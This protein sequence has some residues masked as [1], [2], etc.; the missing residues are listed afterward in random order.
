MIKSISLFHSTLLALVCMSSMH[1]PHVPPPLVFARIEQTRKDPTLIQVRKQ[2]PTLW[3]KAEMLR[4]KAVEAFD[5]NNSTMAD[6][7]GEYSIVTYQHA[8][9]LKHYVDI[10]TQHDQALQKHAILVERI[11]ANE[12]A[13]IETDRKADALERAIRLRRDKLFP[14]RSKVTEPGREQARW[15]SVRANV[16]RAQLLC[17]EADIIGSKLA[18]PGFQDAK[19]L[20]ND[21][22]TQLQNQTKEAPIDASMHAHSLC[23]KALTRARNFNPT[24]SI[25]N[26][27]SLYASVQNLVQPENTTEPLHSLAI[28]RDERGVFA[29]L[30]SSPINK[31]ES[32][33]ATTLESIKPRLEAIAQIAKIYSHFPL[34][35]VLYTNSNQANESQQTQ[36]DSIRQH[37]IDLG[38][39]QKQIYSYFA[40]SYVSK[41]ESNDTVNTV[42]FIWVGSHP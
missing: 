33:T 14:V 41:T 27:T 24:F 13:L 11:R 3:A 2:S 29:T 35:I 18:I 12:D 8:I 17:K 28:M 25:S 23:L 20:L 21:L 36:A 30:T 22:K 1:C 26:T 34:L 10:A 9:A 39:P 6:L 19:Q 37:L 5:Q 42:E 38:I 7:L 4:V 40:D 31:A 32:K 15:L 16:T